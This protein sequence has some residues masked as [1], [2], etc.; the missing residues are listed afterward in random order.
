MQPW[1]LP[2]VF[3]SLHRSLR[4]LPL[5]TLA[6]VFATDTFAASS[7]LTTRA[8]QAVLMEAE[9]GA[10]LFQNNADELVPP[11]SMSKLMTLAVVYKLLKEG[12]L[13]LEDEFTMSENAWRKGG[14]PSGTS[15][16]FV[17]IN[18]KATI[19][20]LLQGV[21]V[22]SGNDAAMCLAEGIA[23]SEQK[24]AVL[25]EEEAR[26][27]GLK[28]SQFRNAT[29]LYHVDHLMT[30]RELAVL[31]RH[32][33]REYPDRYPM[34]A[35]KEFFYRKHK[36]YSRNPL[37]NVVPGIDGMKTGFI[38][39]SGYGMVASAVQ[40]GRRLIAVVGGLET[41]NERRDEARKL[42]EWGYK[43]YA[44]FKL[45]DEGEV[46]G[47]ARVWGGDRMYLPLTGKGELKVLLPRSQINQ[48]L[49]GD[50][51]YMSP[52]KAPI[53]KG[54]E[55]ATLRVTNASGAM[56]EVPL[57]AAEEV[58]KGGMMRRGFDSLMHMAFG[59]VAL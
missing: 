11:A 20:D 50:I 59:W 26:R 30:G 58:N 5:A 37:V 52:L 32:I 2:R 42:L 24:F 16:M 39:E 4:A 44:E 46:V 57:Y 25:M 54:D 35:Q 56:N 51:V 41:E 8:K 33:I 36:F 17:P 27:I 3:S 19:N 38:K 53:A 10:I 31:A 47:S 28:K 9:T 55:V 34:F 14:A 43:G 45:Y 22:Q 49:R 18:T 12:K 6:L 29:G 23:G 13:K 40:E 15:A 48:R 21:I 7:D 1:A